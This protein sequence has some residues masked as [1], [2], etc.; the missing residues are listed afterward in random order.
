MKLRIR[1]RT[2]EVVKRVVLTGGNTGYFPIGHA[3]N[4]VM[5]MREV[6]LADA[7]V[8]SAETQRLVEGYFELRGLGLTELKGI[9]EPIEVFEVVAAGPLTNI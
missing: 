6:A 1:I 2:G 7:I 5:R 9:A 3:S 8:V 4:V